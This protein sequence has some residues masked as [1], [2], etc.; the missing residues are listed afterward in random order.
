MSG[1][2]SWIHGYV[3]SSRLTKVAVGFQELCGVRQ[4]KPH[5]WLLHY[6]FTALTHL[7]SEEA[8][9]AILPLLL[10]FC[11]GSIARET[12]FCWMLLFAGGQF[13]KDVFRLP[14]PLASSVTVL[15]HTFSQEYGFPSTHT[16]SAMTFSFF[17]LLLA[18]NSYERTFGHPDDPSP[19]VNS[20]RS[21]SLWGDI[22]V[23]FA[24]SLLYPLCMSLSRLYFGVCSPL[25]FFLPQL[26]LFFFRCIRS[27]IW[28]VASLCPSSASSR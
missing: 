21:P 6:T 5:N 7:G 25:L 2:Q 4:G 14:R 9:G 22:G 12:M 26:F 28:S 27:Q 3:E 20:G 13:L 16:M 18:I 1:I 15:N 8:Y 17:I 23:P 11:G 10:W 19:H 24:I